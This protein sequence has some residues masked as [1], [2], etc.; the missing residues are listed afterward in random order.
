MTKVTNISNGPRGIRGVAGG[1]VML[2]PR[3][4]AEVDLAAGEEE[5]EWFRFGDFEFGSADAA[6]AAAA[7]PSELVEQ[8]TKRAE[9]AEAMADLLQEELAALKRSAP[10]VAAAVAQLD[11]EN[12]DHW[13]QNGEPKVDAVEAIVGGKVSRA[14]IEAAAPDAKRPT[15]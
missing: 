7:P 13:T 10:V 12:D 14:D 9:D 1:I 8:L 15:A 5:G 6:P 11:P 4:S 2:D 3:Q